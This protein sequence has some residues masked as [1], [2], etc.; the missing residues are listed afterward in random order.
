LAVFGQRIEDTFGFGRIVNAERNAI[1]V[2]LLVIPRRAVATHHDHVTDLNRRVHDLVGIFRRELPRLRRSAV[3]EREERFGAQVLFVK[4]KSREHAEEIGLQV[5]EG[6]ALRVETN[7]PEQPMIFYGHEIKIQALGYEIET[8]VYFWEH[9]RLPRNLL[10][11]AVGINKFRLALI[12]H[13][14]ELYLSH[15][16]E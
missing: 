5:E 13:D 8:T 3:G 1:A 9:F 10:G 14:M 7:R 2:G 16:D 12:E 11:R 4:L 15:Y 6:T